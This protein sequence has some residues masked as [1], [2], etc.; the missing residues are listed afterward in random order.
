MMPVYTYIC[1]SCEV[2][3]ERFVPMSKRNNQLCPA[4]ANLMDRLIG[5][6]R[7][8][9][10]SLNEYTDEMWE[11]AEKKKQKD[12]AKRKAMDAEK[13]RH[14]DK[15]ATKKMEN[16]IVNTKRAGGKG[17]ANFYEKVLENAQK[18]EI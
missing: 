17:E 4:C 2:Q 7:I 12:I 11:R 3:E 8:R 5:A 6:P 14:G 15:E 10:G 18:G 16:R 1:E 9:Y 13:L